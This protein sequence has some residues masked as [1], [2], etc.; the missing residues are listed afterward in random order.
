MSF[1][2]SMI[3]A[4]SSI[5]SN[6]MRTL[7]TMVGIVIG[8][9][10]VSAI[11]S[12]G[13]GFQK[14]VSKEFANLNS[15]SVQIY[16]SFFEQDVTLNITRADVEKVKTLDDVTGAS[17]YSYDRGLVRLKNPKEE[18]G[19]SILAVDPEFAEIDKKQFNIKYGRNFDDRENDNK[20][21]VAVIGEKIAKDVFGRTDV[22][23]EE[24]SVY[25]NDNYYTFKVVGVTRKSTSAYDEESVKIP[26]NTYLEIF[27]K[28]TFDSVYI[29]TDDI[30]KLDKV[31]RS[32]MRAIAINHKTTDD[33]YYAFSNL[34]IIKETQ[35]GI[36]TF[37]LFI[38][39]VAAI[40]LIVGGIGVMNIML[41]TVTERTREI[42]IRKSLGASEN[43]I[44]YQFLIE[45]M[46][47][48]SIG[49]IIGLVLGYIGGNV[50]F[51]VI[52]R[53]LPPL[54]IEL[55]KAE[56]SLTTSLGAMIV[57][58][59]IGVLFG[60]YPAVKAAKLEPTEAFRYE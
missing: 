18:K 4:I 41:V 22:I 34:E 3:S 10:S 50:V 44:K 59:L 40:S 38:S 7:L 54:G 27:N 24:I 11:T 43:D 2:E 25:L 48:C 6:K 19:Y 29:Q 45:S 52:K 37:T 30:K 23:N 53:F 46:V 13:N 39:F 51:N 55:G 35:K 26:L 28:P 12:V 16:K 42:G 21:K 5:L 60:V 57:S 17:G 33:K 36:K 8:V 14:S 47:I 20:L 58:I 49:G 31:K 32:A 15:S 1:I 56:F 9:S